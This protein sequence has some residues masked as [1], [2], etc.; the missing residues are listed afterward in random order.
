ME[1]ITRIRDTGFIAYTICY[2]AILPSTINNH[3]R[4][5]PH[6]LNLETRKDLFRKIRQWPNLI[7]NNNEIDPHINQLSKFP[8]YFTEL[9]LYQDGFSYYEYSYI[10][11]NRKSIQ[12]H[13]R[14]F[15]DWTNPRT[16]GQKVRNN[17]EVPWEVDIPC[18][19]FFYATPGHEYFR[20]TI[21]SDI[22]S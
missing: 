9:T 20:V 3:F 6:R 18:Q 19:Q 8:K 17:D 2:V 7:L 15:H 10:A 22:T 1:Y 4:R 11:R 14:E 16:R 5:A 13:F 12:N 21:S